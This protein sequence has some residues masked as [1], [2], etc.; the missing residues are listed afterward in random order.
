MFIK[1]TIFLCLVALFIGFEARPIKSP[2]VFKLEVSHSDIDEGV[3]IELTSK[4]NNRKT[5][6][7][8]NHRPELMNQLNRKPTRFNKKQQRNKRR[9]QRKKLAQTQAKMLRALTSQKD[10]TNND[11]DMTI[12]NSNEKIV[13]RNK[14]SVPLKDVAGRKELQIEDLRR[15]SEDTE[16]IDEGDEYSDDDEEEKGDNVK[17]TEKKDEKVK[18]TKK[19]TKV[20]SKTTQKANSRRATQNKKPDGYRNYAFDTADLDQLSEDDDL[21]QRYYGRHPA[22]RRAAYDNYGSFTDIMQMSQSETEHDNRFTKR[23][24]YGTNDNFLNDEAKNESNE[25]TND[26]YDEYDSYDD[27]Y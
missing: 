8:V 7:F 1:T 24:H 2:N 9:I 26:I 25:D 13:M 11:L 5:M 4:H 17:V 6:E 16:A 23:L 3:A 21:L 20:D 14:R 27:D 12:Q 15:F 19:D 18:S 22:V 10:E